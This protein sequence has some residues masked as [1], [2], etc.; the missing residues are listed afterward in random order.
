MLVS[1]TQRITGVHYTC[2]C[3]T[4]SRAYV[5]YLY[6]QNH[7]VL[8]HLW[9]SRLKCSFYCQ[10]Y[11]QN[12]LITLE[13]RVPHLKFRLCLLALRTEFTELHYI[14]VRHLKQSL[15]WLP[16][17]LESLDLTSL[18]GVKAYVQ[19]FIVGSTYR[20]SGSHQTYGRPTLSS[21]YACQLYVKNH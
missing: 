11:L 8:V 13:L 20:I 19:P 10:V 21:V 16:L 4:L 17:P 12:Q 9:V 1:S 7:W 15:C 3:A 14:R 5:G 2:G 18:M 6:L